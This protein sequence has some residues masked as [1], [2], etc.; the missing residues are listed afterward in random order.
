MPI[1]MLRPGQDPISL[2]RVLAAVAAVAL[3]ALLVALVG[4]GGEPS[5]RAAAE[6]RIGS[7]DGG[8]ALAQVGSFDNP[9][10]VHYVNN[11]GDLRIDEFKRRRGSTTRA[12]PGSQRNLL[13]IRH[14]P[15][16]NHNGG[17][18]QF[19][20]DGYLWLATGDGGGGGDGLDNARNINALLGKLIRIDPTTKK[21]PYSIPPDNPYVGGDGADEVYAYGL[22]NPWR[23]SFDSETQNLVLADVG[24]DLVE[25]VDRSE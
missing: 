1:P 5:S 9:V 23:F 14:Q 17:Q 15:F 3:L 20:P 22:R 16:S 7:G 10:Y 21:G 12:N 19:G 8:V 24:Q 6:E 18:L 11:D 13:A 2:R 4:A 25:E